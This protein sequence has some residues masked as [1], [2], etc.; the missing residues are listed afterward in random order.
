MNAGKYFNGKIDGIKFTLNDEK[1]VKIT[2]LWYWLEEAKKKDVLDMIHRCPISP[3]FDKNSVMPTCSKYGD[4]PCIAYDRKWFEGNR[5]EAYE[6]VW[7]YF[8][9]QSND[10]KIKFWEWYNRS[11]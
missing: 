7:V 2:L 1:S 11:F 8:D 3:A 10:E 6:V 4:D 5:S 9:Q